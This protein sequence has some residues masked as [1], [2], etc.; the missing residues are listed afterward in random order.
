MAKVS[1]SPQ[2]SGTFEIM[3]PRNYPYT[4]QIGEVGG[5][6]LAIVLFN[7]TEIPYNNVKTDACFFTYSIPFSGNEKIDLIFPYLVSKFAYHGDTV[8]DHCI[9]ETTVVPEFTIVTVVLL[10][11]ITSVIAFH[12][13]K[14]VNKI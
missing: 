5:A 2:T 14:V 11:S 4:N 9:T 10:V 7:G 12:R 3:I 8:P 6:R 1:A 13:L